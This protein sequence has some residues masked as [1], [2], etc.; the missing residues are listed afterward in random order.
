MRKKLFIILSCF[1]I[2]LITSTVYAATK[3]SGNLNIVMSYNL[4]ESTDCIQ[5]KEQLQKIKL[6]LNRSISND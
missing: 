4:R 1:F 2:L 5:G 3:S 6:I